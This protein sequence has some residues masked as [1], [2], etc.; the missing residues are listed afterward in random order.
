MYV[1]N[2]NLRQGSV[3]SVKI[4]QGASQP[5]YSRLTFAKITG[6]TMTFA[7]SGTNLI[8]TVGT[9]TRTLSKNVKYLAFTFPRSDD[10]A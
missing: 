1:I 5:Y 6:N 2:R 10:S 8:Q 4:D 3:G 9:K 7:Q